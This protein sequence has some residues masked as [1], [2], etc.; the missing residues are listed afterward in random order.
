MCVYADQRI[1]GL[2]TRVYVYGVYVLSTIV[3]EQFVVLLLGKKG[4]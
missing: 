1:T 2:G 3:V 4:K